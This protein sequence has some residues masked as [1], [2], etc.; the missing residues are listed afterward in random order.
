MKWIGWLLRL[1]ATILAVSLL[2]VLTTGYVVN[3]YIQ[4]LLGSYNIPVPESSP[5]IGDMMKG[6]LGFGGKGVKDSPVPGKDVNSAQH[7]AN[8]NKTA[9]STPGSENVGKHDSQGI[10]GGGSGGTDSANTGGAT[11]EGGSGKKNGTDEPVPEDAVPAMGGLS[12][13]DAA[14][15]QEAQGQD[16][17]VIV[18]PDDLAAKK[19]G[20]PDKDKEEV[21]SILMS[22]LPQA[23]MQTLTE[24]LEGGLTEAEMINIEQILSKY[25]D[26]S[27]YAKVMGILKK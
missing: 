14:S 1:C 10:V 2:T 7:D 5:S 9:D 24:A 3:S 18:T 17:Q 27:E 11:Q 4:S 16:Q 12:S 23:E 20:L 21:F 22:K 6:M 19:D 25:L 13:Q 15:G 26:K 8:A